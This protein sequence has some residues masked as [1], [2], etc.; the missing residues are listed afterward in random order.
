MLVISRESGFGSS[1][2]GFRMPVEKVVDQHRQ[3]RGPLTQRRQI[4]GHGVD[5]KEEVQ[6]ETSILGLL[7]KISIGCADQPRIDAFSTPALLRA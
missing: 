4:D 2:I 1:T 3:I 6:P 5:A 7:P